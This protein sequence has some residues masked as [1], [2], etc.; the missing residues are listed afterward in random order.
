MF[1][2]NPYCSLLFVAVTL[3][4]GC[5]LE[6]FWGDFEKKIHMGTP[7]LARIA[8]A[9]ASCFSKS[10]LGSATGLGKRGRLPEVM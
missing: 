3:G 4:P 6:P 9:W 1:R 7:N 8:R 2:R 10:L 5:T